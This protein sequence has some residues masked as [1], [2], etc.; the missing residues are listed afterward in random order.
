MTVGLGIFILQIKLETIY[1]FSLRFLDEVVEFLLQI[2]IKG[3][4]FL[5]PLSFIMAVTG[6]VGVGF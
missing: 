2:V 5:E 3:H 4:H 6:Q 1:S